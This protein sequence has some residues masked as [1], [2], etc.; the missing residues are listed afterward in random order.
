MESFIVLPDQL[1]ITNKTL[2][3]L[4]IF[5]FIYVIEDPFFMNVCKSK[6]INNESA[7]LNYVDTLGKLLVNDKEMIPG[8][9]K[10]KIILVKCK[11]LPDGGAMQYISRLRHSVGM[12]WSSCWRYWPTLRDIKPNGLRISFYDPP[13]HLFTWSWS[14][15]ICKVNTFRYFYTNHF[16]RK[17]TDDENL[18]S[19]L[20]A[21][22]EKLN[23][24]ESFIDAKNGT[25]IIPSNFH[26]SNQIDG[27]HVVSTTLKFQRARGAVSGAQIG[28]I[29]FNWGGNN[30]AGKLMKFTMPTN[31]SD[32]ISYLNYVMEKII[33]YNPPQHRILTISSDIE[34]TA[35]NIKR[36]SHLIFGSCLDYCMELGLI[37]PADCIRAAIEKIREIESAIGIGGRPPSR[38]IDNIKLFI[39]SLAN[40]EWDWVKYNRFR[41]T[42]PTAAN[43]NSRNICSTMQA[44]SEIDFRNKQQLSELEPKI[45]IHNI[46][47]TDVQMNSIALCINNIYTKAHDYGYLESWERIIL[48]KFWHSCGVRVQEIILWCSQMLFEGVHYRSV[49]EVHENITE[50]KNMTYFYKFFT[51]D[52]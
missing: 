48:I 19:V 34:E 27:K 30:P 42:T 12:W 39:I 43:F 46:D 44:L 24:G 3:F 22:I 6:N 38:G 50:K 52:I 25:I 47:V 51:G 29:L 26:Q 45:R 33:N 36:N 14:R 28:S 16:V 13:S 8:K 37:L 15:D 2:Q 5:D 11:D 32:T 4:Q 20:C 17:I 23:D 35:K 7:I 9:K 49:I 18:I 40:R 1:F 31:H 21:K 10:T 41:P